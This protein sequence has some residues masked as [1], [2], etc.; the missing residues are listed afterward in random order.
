MTPVGTNDN[1]FT[2]AG[3]TAREGKERRTTMGCNRRLDLDDDPNP[4]EADE[5]RAA[6]R[7]DLACFVLAEAFR[8]GREV[9]GQ[10]LAAFI[11]PESEDHARGAYLMTLLYRYGME[12]AEV[13]ILERFRENVRIGLLS[14]AESLDFS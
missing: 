14:M 6:F 2:P 13:A 10:Y 7:R 11:N 9:N 1:N 12:Q 8:E 4:E 5:S 3:H